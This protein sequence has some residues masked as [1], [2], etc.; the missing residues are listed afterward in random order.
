MSD[1]FRLQ[2][3]F[4]GVRGSTPTPTPAN[5]AYGGNTSCLE[6]RAKDDFIVIDGGTGVR[7]LGI[8]LTEEFPSTPIQLKVFLTHFHWDHIQGLPFFTPLYDLANSVTF[9]S[10]PAEQQLCETLEGQMSS[11]YFPVSFQFLPAKRNFV[12]MQS[13]TLRYGELSITSFPMNHPQRA[14]GYRV[15]SQGA[16]IVFASDLEH[17]HPELDK[18]VRE[19]SEGAD[20]LIYDAQYTPEEYASRKGWGHSTYAE[21]ARV[22]HDAHVKQLI[23][24]HHDPSHEDAKLDEMVSE[25][26]KL[27]ENSCAAREGWSVKL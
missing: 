12:Q 9:H 19:Y 26:K 24:F 13:E 17:G 22:A 20:V 10:F 3:K 25:T 21:A 1:D 5:L 27:F 4:W 18:V 8:S 14:Y 16:V 7:N 11:P 23:L 2:L 15:Q 6:I